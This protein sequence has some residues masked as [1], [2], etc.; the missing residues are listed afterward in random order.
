MARGIFH[1]VERNTISDSLLSVVTNFLRNRKQRVIISGQS[2]SCVSINSGVPQ[3][4]ILG[5]FLFLIYNND[6]CDFL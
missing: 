6:L 3:G 4:S 1:N 5:P 2:L